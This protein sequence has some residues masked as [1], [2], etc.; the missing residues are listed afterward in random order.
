MKRTLC[1]FATAALALV[2]LAS[3]AIADTAAAQPAAASQI[4]GGTPAASPNIIGGQQAMQL[5]AITSLWSPH[6]FGNGAIPAFRCGGTLVNPNWVLTAAHCVAESDDPV[7]ADQLQ[8]RIGSNDRTQGGQLFGVKK[9][10]V[11]PTWVEATA[12]ND[13]AMLQLDHPAI[14]VQ[15]VFPELRKL[16]AGTPVRMLGW[17][18]AVV[19]DNCRYS[20]LPT[21]LN[22]L[23]THV[24]QNSACKLGLA[25]PGDVCTAPAANGGQGCAGDSGSPVLY[26]DKLLHMWELAG[27][28]SRDGNADPAGVGTCT[29]NALSAGLPD[30]AMWVWL[31]IWK[32]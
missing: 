15:P 31:T 2:A 1:A 8:L 10:V 18:C 6:D 9:I 20:T 3:P 13:L 28:V 19:P 29:K 24:L 32:G 11:D 5:P 27:V 23:D 17:G 14:G 7:T 16:Q 30:H 21:V 26:W 25:H 22:Q 4:V 12:D